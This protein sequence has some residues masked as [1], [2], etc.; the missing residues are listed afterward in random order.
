MGQGQCRT[1]QG[2]PS[3]PLVEGR[4]KWKNSLVLRTMAVITILPLPLSCTHGPYSSSYLVHHDGVAYE[5]RVRFTL[6]VLPLTV[7][8]S[9]ESHVQVDHH[10]CRDRLERESLVIVKRTAVQPALGKPLWHR[11]HLRQ[12]QTHMKHWLNFRLSLHNGD[13]FRS[14]NGYCSHFRN[15]TQSADRI[16]SLSPCVWMNHYT[17][18]VT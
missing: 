8:Q 7:L 17:V 1:G 13:R 6:L 11:C 16:P 12:V 15:R 10:T 9:G 3:P 2:Y 5:E 4:T 14:L 18:Y